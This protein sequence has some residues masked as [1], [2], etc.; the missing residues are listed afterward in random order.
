VE[1][2]AFRPAQN[3]GAIT[4]VA[5]VSNDFKLNGLKIERVNTW[6]SEMPREWRIHAEKVLGPYFELMG[7]EP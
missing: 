2:L 7:Y 3:M 6:Q 4:A 5:G 1:D